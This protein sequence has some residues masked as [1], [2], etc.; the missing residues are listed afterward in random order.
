MVDK[1]IMADMVDMVDMVDMADLG[2]VVITDE[3]PIP[4]RN[5][6]LRY[7]RLR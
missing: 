2:E 6:R 5:C 1:V 3:S 4:Y 7:C